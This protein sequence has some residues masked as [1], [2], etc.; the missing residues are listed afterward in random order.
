MIS[1]KKKLIKNKQKN[2]NKN[3]L[4]KIHKSKEGVEGCKND[5]S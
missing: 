4:K 2:K 5:K 1:L 3:N